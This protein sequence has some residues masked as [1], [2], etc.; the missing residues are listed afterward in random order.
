MKVH[1][2]LVLEDLPSGDG[3]S[4]GELGR[5]W[6]GSR[7]GLREVNRREL[8]DDALVQVQRAL[9]ALRRDALLALDYREAARAPQ[10]SRE[11]F[12]AASEKER[13]LRRASS[14][15]RDLSAQVLDL[16]ERL[17]PL[18]EETAVPLADAYAVPPLLAPLSTPRIERER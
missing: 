14:Q 6:V 9:E 1:P 17:H 7:V 5:L 11:R 3:R 16:A 8:D 18:G 15:R 12:E 10:T 2:V 13:A 4:F